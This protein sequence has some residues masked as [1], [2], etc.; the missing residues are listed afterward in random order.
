MTRTRSANNLNAAK[1]AVP[2]SGSDE[3]LG[4]GSRQQ[5]ASGHS[6]TAQHAQHAQQAHQEAAAYTHGGQADPP[7]LGTLTSQ[8]SRGS[9]EGVVQKGPRVSQL[10]PRAGHARTSSLE[11]AAFDSDGDSSQGYRQVGAQLLF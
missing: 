5:L 8:G 11:D 4:S 2:R 6:V 7:P 10:D 3:A 1:P 9:S